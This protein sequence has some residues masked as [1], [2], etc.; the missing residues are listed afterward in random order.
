MYA[1]CIRR[2]LVHVY[3]IFIW[4][5]THSICNMQMKCE[6]IAMKALFTFHINFS[7]CFIYRIHQMYGTTMDTNLT[8]NLAIPKMI[9]I[10]KCSSANIVRF[11]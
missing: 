3:I 10:G 9:C 8:G 7:N 5:C 2:V 6:N 4:R 11:H 1:W